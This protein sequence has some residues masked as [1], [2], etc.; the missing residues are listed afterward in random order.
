MEKAKSPGERI[1]LKELQADINEVKQ[2]LRE[3]Y[4]NIQEKKTGI[5]QKKGHEEIESY[6]KQIKDIIED[7]EK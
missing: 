4:I 5:Q 2:K 6:R 3:K 1:S 7:I